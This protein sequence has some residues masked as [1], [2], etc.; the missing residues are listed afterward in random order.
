MRTEQEKFIIMV[1]TGNFRDA[2]GKRIK[3]NL[4]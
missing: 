3:H 4:E 1:I 2:E